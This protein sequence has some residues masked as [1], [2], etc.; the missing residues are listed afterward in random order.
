MAN[1]GRDLVA[2]SGC[3]PGSGVVWEQ[4]IGFPYTHFSQQLVVFHL[5]R[6]SFSVT[7]FQQK[8]LIFLSHFQT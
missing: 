5:T 3:L 8:V 4:G 6:T 2:Y 7:V 1:T